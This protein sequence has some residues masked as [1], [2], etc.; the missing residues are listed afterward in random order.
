MKSVI[1][2]LNPVPVW[3]VVSTDPLVLK[4]RMMLLPDAITLPSDCKTTARAPLAPGPTG[5]ATV[6]AV[7]N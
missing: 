7:P 5:V 6:P 2:P 3:K 4:R 1:V